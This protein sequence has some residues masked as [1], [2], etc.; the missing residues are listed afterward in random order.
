MK[1]LIKKILKETEE[2]FSW[3]NT[4]LQP[5]EDTRH[6][7]DIIEETIAKTKE[8]K[9]WRIHKD[10][11]DGVVYWNRPGGYTGMATPEWSDEYH[12]P[13][14]ITWGNNGNNY[15][16]VTEIETPWFRY[17]V[18]VEDWYSKNYFE[19]VYQALTNYINRIG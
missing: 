16:N 1:N 14:D 5:I 13:V 3:V 12:V 9:G 17:V 19:K 8:Y 6:R 11:F 7:L 18:E 10:R 2:D 4:E 15:D